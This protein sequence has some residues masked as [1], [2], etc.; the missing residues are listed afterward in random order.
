[1]EKRDHQFARGL[2][3]TT[4]GNVLR[5]WG[6]PTVRLGLAGMAG[7]HS[8]LPAMYDGC[9]VGDLRRLTRC[10]VYALIDT[11]TRTRAETRPV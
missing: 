8:D 9:R 11:C 10:Y 2:S 5:A 3:G 1:V 7:L 4:D 6:I